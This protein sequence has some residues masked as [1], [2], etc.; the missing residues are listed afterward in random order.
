MSRLLLLVLLLLPLAS[1]AQTVYRTTD[2]QGNSNFFEK[3][4]YFDN[5]TLASLERPSLNGDRSIRFSYQYNK[6]GM[7]ISQT[8]AVC[9]PGQLAAS[10]TAT[11]TNTYNALGH[12]ASRVEINGFSLAYAPNALGQP[13]AVRSTAANGLPEYATNISYFP[14][15]ALKGFTY[16]N[17]FVHTLTQHPNQLPKT[18]RLSCTA[19]SGAGSICS[20][21]RCTCCTSVSRGR[22]QALWWA[23]S[24]GAS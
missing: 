10:C 4:T 1:I 24:T 22:S 11:S 13:T 3:R 19:L 8:S 18:S 2:A 21:Q 17:G 5:G 7:P 14:N 6:R 9:A 16:G 15:G 12:L 20:A 23:T